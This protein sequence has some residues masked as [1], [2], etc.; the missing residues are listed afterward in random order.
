MPTR[1]LPRP[2]RRPHPAEAATEVIPVLERDDPTDVI[3]VHQGDLESDRFDDDYD[4]DYD[5]GYDYDDDYGD[6]EDGDPPRKRASVGSIIVRS[7]GELMVTA[8]V[9]VLLFAVYEVWITDVISAGKQDDVTTA[10]DDDW[11][12]Q[13]ER[14]QNF[15]FADGQGIAKMYIPVLGADYKFTIVEGTS[16]KNLEIGPAHYKSTVLPGKP[17]NFSVAGH[18]VGKG[19]P[20][21]DLDLLNACDAIVVETQ[22]AW[23]IYRMLP[24]NDDVATW[25]ERQSDPKC[26]GGEGVGKVEPLTGEYTA[27]VGRQIVTPRQNE[28]V[29]PVPGK[30]ASTL[31]VDQRL[32]MMTLTTCEPKFSNEQRM[33]IQAVLVREQPKNPAD[34][35]Q[36]PAELSETG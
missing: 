25:A 11:Q 19:A 15:E 9:V 18:R 31:P 27:A 29:A 21:N 33:I 3:P 5:D 13:P 10:L 23:H 4:D 36:L 32:K 28:V 12:E 16:E 35:S 8:G 30:P 7:F 22:D 20:F 14:G 24:T 34:L 6:D 1:S 17:G 2:P 26:A